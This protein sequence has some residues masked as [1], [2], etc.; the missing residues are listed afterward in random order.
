MG[1]EIARLVRMA[2]KLEIQYL[3]IMKLDTEKKDLGFTDMKF[4]VTSHVAQ[5]D[6]DNMGFPELHSE[7]RSW[8]LTHDLRKISGA[9]LVGKVFFDDHDN[10]GY[11]RNETY[12]EIECLTEETFKK[13]PGGVFLRTM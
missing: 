5:Y 12:E 1:N 10:H 13:Y 2:I 6:V 8:D 4:R 11:F 3:K 9:S 7:L